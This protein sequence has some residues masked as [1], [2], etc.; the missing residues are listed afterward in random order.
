MFDAFNHARFFRPNAVNGN[1]GSAT[2]GY[3]TQAASPRIAQ[4]AVKFT[5]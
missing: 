4:V 5:F 2:F 3:V 1:I